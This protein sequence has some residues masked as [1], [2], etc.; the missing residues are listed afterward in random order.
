M[1]VI[2]FLIKMIIEDLI[3]K[4]KKVQSSLLEFLEN[5]TNE[6]ENYENFINLIPNQ[7]INEDKHEL[8]LFLRLINEI[9]NNHQRVSNLINKIEKILDQI[10]KDIKKY[11][12]NSQIF[13]LFKEN[14]RILLFLFQ[15]KIIT[16]DESI[17]SK[18]IY[19]EYFAPEKKKHF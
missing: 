18:N 2:A 12:T 5:E 6:E 7:K 4:M 9:S 19:R 13:E 17:V 1:K 14:L 8:R 16:I 15:E 3:D 10:Q 11:F